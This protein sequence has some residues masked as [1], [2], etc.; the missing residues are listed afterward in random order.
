MAIPVFIYVND[1]GKRK[2]NTGANNNQNPEQD[3]NPVMDRFLSGVYIVMGMKVNYDSFRGIY[4][5]LDLCKR[6]WILNSAG[7]FPKAFPIN[8]ITG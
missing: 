8:L 5:Q 3:I 2:E 1:Q 4:M 6:E 7:E